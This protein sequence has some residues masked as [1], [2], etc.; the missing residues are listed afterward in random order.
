[1]E[2]LNLDT[3]TAL[4]RSADLLVEEIDGELVVYDLRTHSAHH[5]SQTAAAVWRRCD[6]CTSVAE[7]GGAIPGSE[8][9]T[10]GTGVVWLALREL[11]S[12]GLLDED[13]QFPKD[14]KTLSRRELLGRAAVLGAGASVAVLTMSVQPAAAA[15]SCSAI[16]GTPCQNNGE[17]CSPLTCTGAPN[18][19]C[20]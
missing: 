17:C 19:T 15:G 6:G 9:G 3:Q 5:L 16:P 10:T 2:P 8:G 14:V 1:M 18:K 12:A 7:I 20:Q 11:T 13:L 4:A